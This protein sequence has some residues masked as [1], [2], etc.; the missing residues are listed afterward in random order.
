MPLMPKALMSLR[1]A[2]LEV[3]YTCSHWNPLDALQI[4]ELCTTAY[5]DPLFKSLKKLL[6]NYTDFP[7]LTT[8]LMAVQLQ[9]STVD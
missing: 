3:C 8:R 9:L 6:S 4:D 5:V 1:V 2:R 7:A